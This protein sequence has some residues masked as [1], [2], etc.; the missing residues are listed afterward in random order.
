MHDLDETDLEILGLLDEDGRRPFSEIASAVG[1]SGPAVSD[2][3]D[4]LQEAGVIRGFTIH[5][6]RSQLR[7]GTPVFVRA[8]PAHDAFETVRQIAIDEDAIEHVFATADGEVWFSARAETGRVRPW[9]NGLLAD[10]T[11]DYDVT[12]LDAVEW[13][14]S[15]TGMEFALT[16]VECG[17]TVD[18][19]GESVR[20]DGN[21]YH[22]CCPSCRARFEER[23]ERFEA[24]T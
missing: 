23:Y 7:A 18:A 1:L 21:V 4:R 11:V 15:V 19:E 10:H 13:T 2:R 8:E 12:L 24:E 3:V 17:N 16:C 9:L 22:F 6:D 20:I 5:L 14:P